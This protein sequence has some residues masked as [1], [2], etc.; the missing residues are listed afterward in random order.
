[1]L[2][3]SDRDEYPEVDA[4]LLI[5]DSE[6]LTVDAELLT[7]EMSGGEES[8]RTCLVCLT[9]LVA[10][11]RLESPGGDENSESDATLSSAG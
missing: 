6:L 9:G 2:S 7:V 8:L 4:K 11:C 3:L 5:V 10:L 1:M